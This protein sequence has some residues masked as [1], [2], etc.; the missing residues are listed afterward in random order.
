MTD[1][2]SIMFVIG[3]AL[4]LSIVSIILKNTILSIVSGLG[5]ALVA[6]YMFSLVASGDPDFGQFAWGFGMMSVILAMAMF[7]QTWWIHRK[8]TLQLDPKTGENFYTENDPD[9]KD[10]QDIQNARRTRRKL[11]G[12]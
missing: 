9:W 7:F 4:I 11:R 5:W 6:M 3:I 10:I 2:L 1:L 8:K 12:R